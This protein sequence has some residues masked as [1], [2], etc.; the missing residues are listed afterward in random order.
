MKLFV[1]LGN[2]G[3][4]HAKHRHNVGFMAADQ[5][6]KSHGFSA[7]RNRFQGQVSEGRFGTEKCMLLK[8][9]TYM[10]ESGRSVGDAMRFYK[11][12]P[13]DVTVFYDELDLAPGKLR[14]KTGGGAAG[15]NGIKS[16][17]SHIG[18]DFTRV[19]IGIGHPGSKGKVSSYVLHDFA[20]A[21]WQWLEPLLDA[22]AAAAPKLADD[23]AAGFMNEVA[24][25]IQPEKSSGTP[26]KNSKQNK[27]STRQKRPSQRDLARNAA[28]K[29]AASDTP[30]TAGPDAM[31]PFTRLRD[32]FGGRK[33]EK[34]G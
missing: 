17:A 7:W 26:E 22:I 12:E 1:G 32:L 18:A 25:K 14:V 20:R 24:L 3:S 23:D 19:R 33:D 10:N 9:Q 6:M 11:L 31:S 15:H 29:P 2:P 28:E 27:S 16:I 30:D 34:K 5:V 4:A 8:P 13:A 21:D